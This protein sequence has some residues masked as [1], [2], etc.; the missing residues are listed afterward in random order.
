M[1]KL[2]LITVIRCVIIGLA[3]VA[4]VNIAMGVY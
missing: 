2:A 3:C 4:F 1:T